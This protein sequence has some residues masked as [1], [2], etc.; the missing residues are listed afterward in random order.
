MFPVPDRSLAATVCN[1]G[2]GGNGM[3]AGLYRV[4]MG[5]ALVDRPP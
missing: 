2:G 1:S 4:A 5:T 3:F